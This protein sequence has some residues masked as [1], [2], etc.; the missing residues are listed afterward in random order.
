MATCQAPQLFRNRETRQYRIAGCGS[1]RCPA[2]GRRL[3]SQWRAVLQWAT[4][5]GCEPQYLITLTVR[6]ALPLWRLAPVGEQ[7]ALKLLAVALCQMLTLA[8]TRLVA[9]IRKGY[10]AFEYVAFVELTTGRR[11]PGHRPH[12][13]LLVRGAE[14]PARWLSR[15]WE[16]HTRGSFKVDVQRLRSPQ[17]AA[18]YLVGY[19]VGHRKKAQQIHLNNWPGPRV[20]YSRGYFPETVATIRREL[21]TAW[22][23][24]AWP[25]GSWEWMGRLLDHWWH[26]WQQAVAQVSPGNSQEESAERSANHGGRDRPEHHR[27]S[28]PVPTCKSGWDDSAPQVTGVF[29]RARKVRPGCR[30]RWRLGICAAGPGGRRASH[31]VYAPAEATG[32][33]P[34]AE[35]RQGGRNGCSFDG[36]PTCTWGSIPICARIHPPRWTVT[37]RQLASH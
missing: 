26:R 28:D 34:G 9:E 32:S 14:L 25:E 3:A 31:A 2:C 1:W 20:R 16:F 10:G 35:E 24:E 33:G 27:Q 7:G 23:A 17:H 37:G 18:S 4:E 22:Q 12:L 11:T 29:R 13:H 19:T 36:R 8:L 15:R 5:H 21:A 30:S 6:E